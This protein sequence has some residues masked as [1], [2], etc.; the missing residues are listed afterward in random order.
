MLTTIFNRAKI[1]TFNWNNNNNNTINYPNYLLRA[2]SSWI[3]YKIKI[4]IMKALGKTDIIIWE[5]LNLPIIYVREM[6]TSIYKAM[7]FYF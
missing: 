7:I 4:S 6:W 1:S 3:G 2:D 5:V